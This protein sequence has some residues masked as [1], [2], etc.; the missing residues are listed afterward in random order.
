MRDCNQGWFRR[1]VNFFRRQLLQDGQLPF[2]DILNERRI[3][4]AMQA[5]GEGW[6][7]RIYTPIV[8]LWVLLSQVFSADHSCRAA[9][10]RLIAHRLSQGQV[11]CS[12]RTGAYCQAHKRLPEKFFSGVARYV[13][14][15]LDDQSEQH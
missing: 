3:E 13:G 9:V 15:T 4:Q 1:Q 5:V 14:Q 8:T 7:D 2:G 11:A 6:I 12:A 10:A